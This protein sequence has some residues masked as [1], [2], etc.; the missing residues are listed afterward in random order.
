V[1]GGVGERNQPK[2]WWYLPQ[3]KFHRDA[4][5]NGITDENLLNVN[6]IK[7]PKNGGEKVVLQKEIEITL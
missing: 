1:G 2:I 6:K 5:W 7:A 4:C 3:S